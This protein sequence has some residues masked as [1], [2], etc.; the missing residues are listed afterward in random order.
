MS[1]QSTMAGTP[2]LTEVPPVVPTK[3]EIP[4]ELTKAAAGDSSPTA[5]EAIKDGKDPVES[6]ANGSEGPTAVHVDTDGMSTTSA[7]SLGGDVSGYYPS[8]M[9]MYAQ[10]TYTT[11]GVIDFVQDMARQIQDMAHQ[12]Q[13][14]SAHTMTLRALVNPPES[15]QYWF[16]QLQM[17]P[18]GI[19][20]LEC[21]NLKNS[22][23]D[24]EGCWI[25]VFCW[26]C[27]GR[28]ARFVGPETEVTALGEIVQE[29]VEVMINPELSEDVQQTLAAYAT[30]LCGECQKTSAQP[31][32]KTPF[33]YQCLMA[34]RAVRSTCAEA[35]GPGGCR[36]PSSI[37][38]TG[39]VRPCVGCLHI[40]M[41]HSVRAMKENHGNVLCKWCTAGQG[42][43]IDP[44]SKT[45]RA[46]FC[47]VCKAELSRKHKCPV[48]GC[49]GHLYV[50]AT[51]TVPGR[52]CKDCNQAG[53]HFCQTKK[54]TTIIRDG[55]R[56]AACMVT[57][58]KIGS[59]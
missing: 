47:G 56:C 1:D 26:A 10:A 18:P 11:T 29:P 8:D 36:N 41:P 46:A 54:C 45:L 15:A 12:I 14:L 21:I 44:N 37:T 33:C 32:N 25:C 39:I 6:A 58:S 7:I 4:M 57:L 17:L 50:D 52:V 51:G 38:S 40:K 30:T 2:V 48:A 28:M 43:V 20:C 42:Y 24:E 3:S 35:D 27:R 23:V 55:R 31:G 5:P 59:R 19:I 49:E 16:A 22:V 53:M 34:I 13:F 9:Q